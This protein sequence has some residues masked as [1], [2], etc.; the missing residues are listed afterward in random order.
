MDGCVGEA[1]SSKRVNDGL[2]HY[3]PHRGGAEGGCSRA[4]ATERCRKG[5]CSITDAIDCNLAYFVRFWKGEPPSEAIIFGGGGESP[6]VE[7]DGKLKR[8]V[9]LERDVAGFFFVESGFV[10]EPS[11]ENLMVSNSSGEFK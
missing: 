11:S 7:C 3:D 9:E 4:N 2:A 5:G 6:S 8:D 1:G 10:W